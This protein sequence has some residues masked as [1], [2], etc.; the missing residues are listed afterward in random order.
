[1]TMFI[2]EFDIILFL[3]VLIT[4][5]F[6]YKRGFSRETLSIG[7][8]ILA[9]I[10]TNFFA[11]HLR[12]LLIKSFE[13]SDIL[14]ALI[15]YFVIF[16]IFIVIFS[17]FVKKASI[18]LHKT[19]FKS[20]DQGLGFL[21]GIIKGIAF[22]CLIYIFMIWLIPIKEKR[23]DWFNNARSEPFLK[24]ASESLETL[25]IPDT[26]NSIL[27]KEKPSKLDLLNNNDSYEL[28]LKPAIKNKGDQNSDKVGYTSEE[29]KSLEK[30]LFQIAN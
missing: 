28:L 8:W 24:I 20:I 30:V 13:L 26:K 19:E 23:P 21:F 7:A 17:Y 12:D 9:I 5:F 27:R 1:M 2:N 3:V 4:A 14:C 11:P 10:T 18:I 25:L 6:G 16:L 29:R 15:A 22:C